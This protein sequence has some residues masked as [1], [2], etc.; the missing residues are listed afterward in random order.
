MLDDPT[1]AL[2]GLSQ[3]PLPAASPPGLLHL[4]GA[5]TLLRYRT[6]FRGE[7][8]DCGSLL[9]M[10]QSLRYQVYCLERNFEEAAHFPDR[11][12]TDR[13][14]AQSVHGVLF[15]RPWDK[16]IGTTRLILSPDG[17]AS[18]P[19]HALLGK[20][21]L[22]RGG[23]PSAG[24]A[25]VSR[26]AISRSFRPDDGERSRLPC[27]G[28]AQLLLRLS[29][30]H[31]VTHWAALMQPSLLRML[32]RMGIEFVPVGPLVSYR[33]LRQP[34]CCEL[35]SMLDGLYRRYPANWQI[36]T[37]GGRLA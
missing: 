35:A 34:S 18:L 36:V 15:Y 27:L 6:Y 28:L 1:P 25:E 9:R 3:E 4:E 32:A 5:R 17:P 11:L 33:G 7:T 2:P 20:A 10:A 16:A 37:D 19:F 8:A 12:E 26:F 24:M 13:Y 22:A 29:L 31:G 23:F 30:M 14:D 21:G